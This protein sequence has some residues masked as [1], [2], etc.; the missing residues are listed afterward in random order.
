MQQ[1]VI[2]DTSTLLNRALFS[3]IPDAPYLWNVWLG[4]TLGQLYLDHLT[5]RWG[6]ATFAA[7]LPL[8]AVPLLAILWRNAQK[9]RKHGLVE[10][11]KWRKMSWK[12]LVQHL[13]VELDMPGTF[14]L[15]T[16]FTLLLLPL[17]LAASHPSSWRSFTILIMF[18]IGG[19]C[20]LG[21]IVW[22]IK[23][24]DFPIVTFRLMKNRTVACGCFAGFWYFLAYFIFGQYFQ[25]YLQVARF[26]S[27]AG[28]GR[29]SYISCIIILILVKPS[30]S[31]QQY[32][33][34]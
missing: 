20:L 23:F 26:N 34:S 15:T 12:E 17:A 24:A 28:A 13:F 2:A 32:L 29:I 27:A 3:S 4:P 19:L 33:I 30:P 6:Y 21:F 22:D 10:E 14:L 25:S 16:G 31:P 5:W 7:L 9:A 18:I 8:C 1:I 11:K